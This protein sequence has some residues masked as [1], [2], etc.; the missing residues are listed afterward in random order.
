MM[1]LCVA[2][3]GAHLGNDLF[4]D[5]GQAACALSVRGGLGCCLFLALGADDTLAVKARI[6]TSDYLVHDAPP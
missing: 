2:Y 1:P 5:L 3:G 4:A 6:A